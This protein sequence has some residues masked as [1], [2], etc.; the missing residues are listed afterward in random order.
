MKFSSV[1]CITLASALMAKE[2]IKT[3]KVAVINGKRYE[4]HEMPEN[5]KPE[6]KEMHKE[7]PKRRV[8]KP[9]W[10]DKPYMKKPLVVTNHDNMKFNEM[11]KNH[12][13]SHVVHHPRHP[14]RP[15][16]PHHPRHKHGHRRPH[17]PRC[18]H[19]ACMLKASRRTS[20]KAFFKVVSVKEREVLN[21]NAQ[22]IFKEMNTTT[23]FYVKIRGK[24]M[25]KL[26]STHSRAVLLD[27]RQAM[28]NQ[29]HKPVHH[30]AESKIFRAASAPT[31]EQPKE[32]GM[33]RLK[34]GDRMFLCFF[35][36]MLSMLGFVALYK[37]ILFLFAP[38]D[39][40][41]GKSGYNKLPSDD[42]K[43]LIETEEKKASTESPAIV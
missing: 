8:N 28:M 15:Q 29:T 10:Q 39:Y 1:V 22:P 41:E 30:K 7:A 40:E 27:N 43:L 2:V 23:S 14:H 19:R 36:G 37:G 32:P 38:E 5:K 6:H 31:H 26:G 20:R 13:N 9:H 12:N 16:R 3:V 21:A 4:L 18:Q 11:H 33:P 25:H 24:P 17:R 42:N 35:L 34:E